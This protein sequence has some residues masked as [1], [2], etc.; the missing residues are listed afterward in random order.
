MDTRSHYENKPSYG[1]SEIFCMPKIF[2]PPPKL[3]PK[4]E[5]FHRWLYDGL[6]CHYERS[7]VCTI[8][9]DF[10]NVLIRVA[11]VFK[12]RDMQTLSD[13]VSKT[14]QLE[15]DY[16]ICICARVPFLKTLAVRFLRNVGQG[17]FR[18]NLV[19]LFL[20]CSK[21]KS[22][23]KLDSQICYVPYAWWT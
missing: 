18:Q 10:E 12:I 14:R 22:C 5:N 21:D 6:G 20:N 1:P 2:R 3:S 11:S 17:D 7:D 15:G 23:E 16:T 8:T 19:E 4:L 13:A 9:P